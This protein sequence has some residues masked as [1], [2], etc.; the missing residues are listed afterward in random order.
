[1]QLSIQFT[2]LPALVAATHPAPPSEEALEIRHHNLQPT[3]SMSRSPAKRRAHRA[4]KHG[5]R[6]WAKGRGV[7]SAAVE[8]DE[9]AERQED[10]GE[11]DLQECAA[12]AS[13]RC[14]SLM[15]EVHLML[16]RD[17]DA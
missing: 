7:Y 12:V 13:W 17:P 11:E 1:M 6:R 9:H 4:S 3:K 2:Q 15:R 10:D 5:L 14:T 16:P 8:S